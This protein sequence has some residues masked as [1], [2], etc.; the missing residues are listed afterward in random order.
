MEL[1]DQLERRI[2]DL[3]SRNE[4]LAAENALLKEGRDQEYAS[5]KEE[6]QALKQELELERNK[7]SNALTR[8]QTLVD[9]I[10]EQADQE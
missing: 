3:L 5:L 10:R 9:R 4:A 7:N 1:L 8:I 2:G 6:N